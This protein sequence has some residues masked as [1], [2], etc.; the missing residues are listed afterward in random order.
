MLILAT[1]VAMIITYTQIMV[2]KETSASWINESV[3]GM[4]NVPYR[5]EHFEKLVWKRSN[6]TRIILKDN[7]EK[8]LSRQRKKLNF[9]KDSN[10]SCWES[11]RYV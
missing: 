4:R 11:I 5:L 10:N 1:L 7:P 2:L 9:D 6:N 8:V 3:S